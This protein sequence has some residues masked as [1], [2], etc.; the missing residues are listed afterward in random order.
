MSKTFN[1]TKLEKKY[2][3]NLLLHFQIISIFHH[4]L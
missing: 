1:I 2:V 3:T 4:T